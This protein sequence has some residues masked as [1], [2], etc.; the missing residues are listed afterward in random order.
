MEGLRLSG[1]A[2]GCWAL[3]VTETSLGAVPSIQP[4]NW[5]L[6]GTTLLRYDPKSISLIY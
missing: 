1:I 5:D 2:R 6:T 4:G 3:T